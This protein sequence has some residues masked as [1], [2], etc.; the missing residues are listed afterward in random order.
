MTGAQWL[1]ASN[2]TRMLKG[3]RHRASDRK[4]R[5]WAA[6]C[7]RHINKCGFGIA[8]HAVEVAEVYADGL[9][10]D[11]ELSLARQSVQTPSKWESPEF[12]EWCLTAPDAREAASEVA[13]AVPDGAAY[14]V[15]VTLDAYQD[16][17]EAVTYFGTPE[18]ARAEA[19]AQCVELMR[20]VFGN[21]FRRV[22]HKKAWFTST[23][24]ALA[25]GIYAARASDRLPIL[26]DA[27]EDA[28]CDNADILTHLRGDGPHVRGCW[29]VDLIL[30][31]S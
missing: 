19:I 6:G 27:L 1:A 11:E 15:S 28:G 5:L 9:A 16:D 21:P 22:A 30:G 31:K 3:L 8:T 13:C 25:E 23:V 12:P 4:L 10:S 17:P 29:A 14:S 20:C 2:P 18:Q 7:C 26:A 24:L